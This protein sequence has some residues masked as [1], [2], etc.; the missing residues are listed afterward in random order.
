MSHHP[1]SDEPVA[2]F[3]GLGSNLGDSQARLHSAISEIDRLP[4]TGVGLRSSLFRSLPMGVIDQPLFLNAVVRIETRLP[5]AALLAE[6]Q[7]IERRFGR[8]R[9]LRWGPRSLDL[10]IL[11]YGNIILDEPGLIIP[12]PGIPSRSFVL[13]PLLQ[14]APGLKIPGMGTP[15]DL[16]RHCPGPVPKRLPAPPR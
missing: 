9:K 1:L 11:V 6:L 3:I 10:D 15:S 12:H 14:I 7:K 8:I 2:A 16:I 13:Y 4:R 5:P